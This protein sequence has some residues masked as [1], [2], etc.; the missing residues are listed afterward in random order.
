MIPANFNSL[1]DFKSNP[2]IGQTWKLA[3]SPSILLRKI[4]ILSRTGGLMA[5]ACVCI[6]LGGRLV[7]RFETSVMN[8]S[9]MG[10]QAGNQ[11]NP[12]VRFSNTVSAADT[13]EYVR[14][15]SGTLA[16][17]GNVY[18]F[19]VNLEADVIEFQMLGAISGDME[20]YMAAYQEGDVPPDALTHV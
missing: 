6:K 11:F 4:W 16:G 15:V 3:L 7:V 12:F 5:R 19:N 1:A 8:A 9:A 20:I 14:N 10:N 13:M 18:P 17:I 2:A